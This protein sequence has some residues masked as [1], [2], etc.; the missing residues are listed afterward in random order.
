MMEGKQ[1]LVSV[2]MATYNSEKFIRESVE[3]V[4]KQTYQNWELIV[5]DDCSSDDTIPK[6]DGLRQQR[7][8]MEIRQTE[9]NGGAAIARNCCL[10]AAN[11]RYIAFLDSDDIWEA[12]KLE[13]QLVFMRKKKSAISCTSFRV[14]DMNGN[15][16]GIAV[17]TGVPSVVDYWGLLA[18]KITCG[19]STVIVDRDVVGDFRMPL[20]RTGQDYATWLSLLRDGRKIYVLKSVLTSYRVRPDSLSRNVMVKLRRQWKIYRRHEGLS[21]LLSAYYFGNYA[22]RA[23]NRK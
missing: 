14:I 7:P 20:A 8:N 19:C 13:S 22:Y 16:T 6:L 11:G 1:P 15:D 17:D 18:K 5:T 9:R 10:E 23:L 4:F 2:I 12:S 21:L 3:S